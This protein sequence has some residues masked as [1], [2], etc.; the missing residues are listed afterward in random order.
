MHVT[1]FFCENANTGTDGKLNVQ[2]I[3]NELS[4]AGFPAKQDLV[5]LAGIIEWDRDD[6][7]K[8]TFKIDIIDPDNQSIFTIDANS[9]IE[10]RSGS[11]PPA[12]SHLIFPLENLI[13]TKAGQYR[14]VMTIKN[15]KISGS[16]LN[17]LHLNR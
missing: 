12:I 9:E 15:E 10:V 14:T 6:H 8:Q 11:R 7:G 3:Y 17:L 2:G 4:S 5:T 16:S 1:L 13:F